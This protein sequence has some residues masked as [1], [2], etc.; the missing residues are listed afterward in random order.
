MA[1]GVTDR[2]WEVSD[3]VALLEAIEPKPGKR[4]L[5][6][7]GGLNVKG[8]VAMSDRIHEL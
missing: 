7:E 5:Q 1:A 4:P 3:I 2:L 8:C 6:A